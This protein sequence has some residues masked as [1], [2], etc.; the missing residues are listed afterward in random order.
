M[1]APISVWAAESKRN[2]R[3]ASLAP[4]HRR[5]AV[6]TKF[7]IFK[8]RSETNF[9]PRV[10][11]VRWAAAIELPE[12]RDARTRFRLCG[13]PETGAK[14][15]EVLK[16]AALVLA[17][18]V[19]SIATATSTPDS[20]LVS[21][22]AWWEKVTVTMA[23]DGN[24]QSCSYQTSL[25]P[26]ASEHCDVSSEAAAMTKASDS[27]D[28]AVTS[29]T[30]ER[31]FS[32]GAEPAKPQVGTGDTLLGG[33][34]LALNIDQSGKVK[35]CKVVARSGDVQPDYSCDDAVAERFQASLGTSPHPARQGYMTVI[36]YGHSEHMA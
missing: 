21:N 34:V 17:S 27:N 35:G 29:I 9:L 10:Q 36:V 8:K 12:R 25:K 24:A 4:A 19:G 15:C 16:I 33:Q 6:A 7:S 30:F 11:R 18:A 14:E 23:G 22:T 5:P 20:M 13:V 2:S 1:P 28:N 32:P 3:R 31:R 26:G